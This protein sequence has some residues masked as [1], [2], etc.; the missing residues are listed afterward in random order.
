MGALRALEE[1]G[2]L[3]ELRKRLPRLIEEAMSLDDLYAEVT[4][5]LYDAY[6]K[7]SR[8]AVEEARR[9]ARDVLSRWGGEGY[10]L[11]HLYRLRIEA[12]CDVYAG[13]PHEAWARVQADWPALERSRLLAH[14]MV[15]SDALL[16]R[17]RV[18]LA[19]A[20][21]GEVEP[22]ARALARMQRPDATAAASLLRAAL[23]VRA[24]DRA[25]ALALLSDAEAAYASASMTLHVAY[26]A[27]RRGELLGE[28]A[29]DAAVWQ[30]D[31]ALEQA[32]IRNPARWLEIQA[33]GFGTPPA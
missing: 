10:Q 30:A 20:C 15:H 16:L 1:L 27:R 17:A 25:R 5:R 9:D 3:E 23:A 2:R 21:D 6:W 24:G 22:A 31:R 14:R 18:A 28:D 13:A 26:A 33:P 12:C 11:Q 4:F 32:G 7:I 8:G 19:A 29:G